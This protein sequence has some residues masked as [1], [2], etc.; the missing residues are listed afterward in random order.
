VKKEIEC[1]DERAE[2]RFAVRDRVAVVR[3]DPRNGATIEG[4]LLPGEIEIRK[5]EVRI[6]E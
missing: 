1:I 2:M 3:S 6:E 4:K 5:P